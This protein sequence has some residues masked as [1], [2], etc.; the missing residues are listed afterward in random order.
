MGDSEK[1]DRAQEVTGVVLLNMGGPDSLEAVEPFLFNLFNDNDIIPLPLGGL[2]IQR[3]LA[4][5]ISSRRAR[6]V[7]DYYSKIGGKSPLA[8]ITAKQAL[9]LERRLEAA[10]HPERRFRCYVAMRYWHPFTDAAL[11]RM[12]DDG[13]TR[14]VALTLYPH[15]TTATTESSLHELRRQLAGPASRLGGLAGAELLEIDR[16]F[17]EPHYLDALARRVA[18][19]LRKFPSAATGATGASDASGA[20]DHRSR[21]MLLFSAHGLPVSFIAKGDPYV[22][23]LHVT[24]AGVLSRLARDHGTVYDWRLSYQSRA[25]RARW[26]EPSTEDALKRLAAEGRR[27]VLVIPVAFVSDHIETLYEIDMLFGDEARALG[28][29]FR[30]VPALNLDRGFVEALAT[31]VE[32]KLGLTTPAAVGATTPAGA[33]I[34]APHNEPA[35]SSTGTGS[36]SA[37]TTE[38]R[39]A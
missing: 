38:V 13:V 16:W 15:Y 27:D 5:L 6:F 35:V 2:V 32:R 33:A 14:V 10:H 18:F 19:S 36:G 9:L 34:A 3:R 21:V 37:G 30:R 28:L 1:H 29:N 11:A 23:H 26:L 17:D 8:K 39:R 20:G 12:R 25:G 24:I 7:R 31:L 4:K 22:E